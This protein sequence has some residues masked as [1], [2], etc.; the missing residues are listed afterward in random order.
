MFS[1]REWIVVLILVLVV[2]G[3]YGAL[4]LLLVGQDVSIPS[5]PLAGNQPRPTP[6][7]ELL[8][9]REA[10][11]LAEKVAKEWRSDARLSSA[12]AAWS[13]PTMAELTTGRTAWGFSFVSP[14][15]GEKAILAVTGQQ[16][17]LVQ[18]QRV[19]KVPELLD[20]AG[21]QVDSPLAVRMFLDHEGEGFLRDH[22]DSEIHLRLSTWAEEGTILWLAIGLSADGQSSAFIQIDAITARVLGP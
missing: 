16:A 2:V 18:V 8:T 22:P 11:P 5:P 14:S 17:E 9:A 20:V 7:W 4:L 15:A 21:W 19:S 10:Y 6:P 13:Q 1:R 3:I 12:T